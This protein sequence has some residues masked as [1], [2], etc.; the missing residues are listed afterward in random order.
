MNAHDIL[1]TVSEESG[2]SHDDI[3]R[4]DHHW[5]YAWPRQLAMLLIRER[6]G[7]S[8]HKIARIMRRDHTTILH[9]C[10]AARDR[11]TA[12]PDYAALHARVCDRLDR[13]TAT[14]EVNP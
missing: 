1:L 14:E 13:P 12:V 5:R 3:L 4:P 9:G 6:C 10:R 11:M 8:L 2:I 7:Y